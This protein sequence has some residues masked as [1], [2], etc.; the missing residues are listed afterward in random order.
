MDFFPKYEPSHD[1][2]NVT[3]ILIA[4]QLNS[5]KSS[6]INTWQSVFQRAMKHAAYSETTDISVT[7]QVYMRIIL[8][9]VT[10][11]VNVALAT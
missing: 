3:R 10:C 4:G 9:P 6:T 7:R 1:N 11:Q 2:V 8:H 5:G